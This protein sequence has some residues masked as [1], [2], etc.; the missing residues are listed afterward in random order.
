[1]FYLTL[2]IFWTLFWSFA[3]VLI[4]RLH[5]WESGILTGRS[6]CPKCN[7][8]LSFGDLIPILSWIKNLWKCKYCKEKISIIY[9]LL[10]ISTWILFSLIWYFLI[11]YNLLL[12]G[13]INE[14]L[15]LLFWLFIWF[16]SILYIFYDIKFLEIHEW[17]LW[18]WIFI[19]LIII[20]FQSFWVINII[21][22]LP[23]WNQDFYNSTLY[24]VIILLIS[25]SGLYIIMLKEFSDILDTLI[26]VSILLIIYIFKLFS[27][28][29]LLNLTTIN[30]LIWALI[31]F[32]F[33]YIQYLLWIVLHQIEK[34]K[35]KKE[36][37]RFQDWIIWWWDLRIAILIWLL[38]G[39]YLAPAWLMITYLIGSIISIFILLIQKIYSKNWN[40]NTQIPFWP[41]LAIWFFITL[42]FYK[43]INYLLKIYFF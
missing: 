33:F 24:S 19:S 9:P 1:M 6:H 34:K 15:K 18:A 38:L 40:I 31:I 7:H 16:I 36:E 35:K 2:F 42:F 28:E 21:P 8:K 3:S 10:E 39:T 27:Q 26:L 17:I 37:Y 41:F 4:H 43:Q 23:F 12:S 32:I 22:T 29:N 13:N 11:N 14:I 20:I 5:S 25:I 30:A